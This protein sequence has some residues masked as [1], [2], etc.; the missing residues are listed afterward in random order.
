V[1]RE[2]QGD[3]MGCSAGILPAIAAKMAALQCPANYNT[4]L[5]IRL[6]KKR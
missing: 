6:T 2:L 3:R 1:S 5:A 4:T